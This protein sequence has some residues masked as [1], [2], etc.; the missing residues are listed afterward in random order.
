MTPLESY[1]DMIYVISLQRRKDRRAQ[2]EETL[3]KL[4]IAV[5]GVTWFD[6]Y[7]RPMHDGQPSGNFGCTASHA[8]L[9]HIIAHL[10]IPRALILEDD[11]DVAFTGPEQ[12]ARER[13]VPGSGRRVDPQ[14]LFQSY[15]PEIPEAWDMLYLGRHFAEM[16]QFRLSPHVVRI[17]RVLT[18]SSYAITAKFA[19]KIAPHISGVGPIDNLLG[20]YHR[21]YACFC[22]DPTLFIQRPCHSD[23]R[24]KFE[25]YVGAM[26]D[27]KHLQAL[28]AGKTYP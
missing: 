9:Y 19:R 14:S 24:E 23:L 18:T 3:T 15:L 1:F 26:Q 21:D 20:G 10:N 12:Y 2:A 27:M 8:A 6:A 28:D 13:R 25:D 16:P 5:E 4:G 11:F 7:D 17:G 22:V